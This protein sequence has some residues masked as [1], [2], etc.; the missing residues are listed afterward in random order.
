MI[1]LLSYLDLYSIWPLLFSIVCD[2]NLNSIFFTQMTTF[3]P[4]N[5]LCNP[6]FFCLSFYILLWNVLDFPGG[7]D[8]KESACNAGP[9]FS[10][11]VRKIPWK[12]ECQ[13]TPVFLPGE[14]CGQR[15][16]AGYRPW[17]H[18]VENQTLDEWT[19]SLYNLQLNFFL[20]LY[21]HPPKLMYVP[22]V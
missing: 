21:I 18:I 16:L 9:G 17:G 14:F 12:R 19:H 8:S 4:I 3:W 13:P 20:T 11:W 7:S 1:A 2:K 15:S 6:N 5:L 10:P 22:A